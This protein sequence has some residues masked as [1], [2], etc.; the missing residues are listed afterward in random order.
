MHLGQISLCDSVGYNIK[1][2]EDKKRIL[3]ELD[4]TYSVRVIKKH[5]ENFTESRHPDIIK[6]NP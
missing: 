3:E 1:S 2:D 4:R 6:G 5:H